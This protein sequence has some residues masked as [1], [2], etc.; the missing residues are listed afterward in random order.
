MK[1]PKAIE[2]VKEALLT[3]R[4]KEFLPNWAEALSVLL[5]ECEKR[6]WISVK[7]KLPEVHQEVLCFWDKNFPADVGIYC[8]DEIWQRANESMDEYDVNPI[9]WMPLPEIPQETI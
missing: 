4:L 3:D 6:K 5:A 8:G 7:D 2:I 9:Y 1:L